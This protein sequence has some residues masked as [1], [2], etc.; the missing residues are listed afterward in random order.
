[1]IVARAPLR[2]SL[3]G[4]GTDL[5]AYANQYGGFCVSAA[6]DKYVYVIVNPRFYKN[7]LRVAYLHTEIVTKLDDLKHDLYRECLRKVGIHGGVE[8]ASMADAPA[9]SGLGSSSSFTVACLLA[10]HAHVGHEPS[11]EQ[12]A[13]E[14]CEIEIDTLVAPIGKQ[15]QYI[16]SYG[17]I[18]MMWFEGDAVR[19]MPVHLGRENRQALTEG[20]LVFYTGTER[21]AGY[22]LKEQTRAILDGSAVERMHAIKA[23]G[24]RT[25]AM[26]VAGAFDQYGE[27]LHEHWMA[28][29]NLASSMTNPQIDECYK[30]ARDAGAIGGKLMGA[31]G[32]GFFLFYVRQADRAAV[33]SAMEARGLQ[34]LHFR[35]GAHGAHLVTNKEE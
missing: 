8:L 33:I 4:G 6:I 18:R 22:V 15:D 12:L 21:R 1:V 9:N 19:L 11:A 14:A 23:M 17:G 25:K 30:A 32:G 27:L 7:S 26:L 24:E 3:G 29:R 35:L 5:P 16:A 13:R 31:G 2:I 28:K 34:Q 10:L 20:L